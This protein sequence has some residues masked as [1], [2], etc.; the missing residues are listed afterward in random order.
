MALFLQNARIVLSSDLVTE[1]YHVMPKP[2]NF[3]VL[4]TKT[5]FKSFNVFLDVKSGAVLAEMH[6][7]FQICLPQ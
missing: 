6:R 1:I 4:G 5:I 3:V 7:V 2:N